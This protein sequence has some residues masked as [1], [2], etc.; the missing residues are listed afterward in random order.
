M[1]QASVG[2]PVG[3]GGLFA[4]AARLERR[5]FVIHDD[6]RAVIAPVGQVDETDKR[7]AID[8]KPDE[9]LDIQ[10]LAR[11]GRERFDRLPPLPEI[12]LPDIG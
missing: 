12:G 7:P 8:F 11:D 3:P 4:L 9:L 1:T 10:N 5:G 6:E 2:L